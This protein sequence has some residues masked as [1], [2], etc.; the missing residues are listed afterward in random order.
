MEIVDLQQ[1]KTVSG[2]P[3][4]FSPQLTQAIRATLQKGEQSLVFLNRRG[5]SNL[6]VCAQCGQPVQCRHCQVSLTLHQREQQ[7]L[8]HYCGYTAPAASICPNCQSGRFS[9]FGFGTERLEAELAKLFP[10]ARIGRL[11]RDT[12]RNR[13]DFI[14]I[15]KGVHQGEIDILIGTQMITKGHHF[16]NVTLVGVV[17]PDAGL[18]MPDY[19]AGERTFQLLSQVTGR[20]GRGDKPGRVLI[21]THQPE[22]YSIV[23]AMRHDYQA[24]YH[25]ELSFRR[26]LGFPPFSR[27][28]NLGLDAEEE[29]LVQEAA[30]ELFK[31]AQPEA[32]RH[33]VQLLGPAPA[34]LAKLHGRHRWQLL[35]KGNEFEKLHG[36]LGRLLQALPPVLRGTKVKLTVDVDPESMV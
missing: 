12:S 17:W 29:G 27:L 13:Q 10:A 30:R 5:Y 2:H 22:H 15:L 3:P 24:F 1:V 14:N 26:Q 36:F 6:V 35:L 33:G 25:Q 8:C 18:G 19:K 28:I 16:P 20:A 4:L 32:G 23:A 9:N 31:L 11:D 21:Q 7:L 34:V